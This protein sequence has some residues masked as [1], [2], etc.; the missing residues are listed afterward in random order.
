MA[1]VL[2]QTQTV[3]KTQAPGII[4]NL[5]RVLG[6]RAT[7]V[8]R[9]IFD[10]TAR[11]PKTDSRN[12]ILDQ[13]GQ[14]TDL[15]R[16]MVE[17][18]SRG[19]RGLGTGL[20]EIKEMR[21]KL[22][23]LI[24]QMTE[25]FTKV[26]DP[27]RMNLEGIVKELKGK[28]AYKSTQVVGELKLGSDLVAQRF[29]NE[30][31][32]V[33]EYFVNHALREA[34]NKNVLG[35]NYNEAE[36]AQISKVVD[37]GGGRVSFHIIGLPESV[38]KKWQT[39]QHDAIAKLK[40]S[41]VFRSLDDKNIM[42]LAGRGW[43]DPCEVELRPELKAPLWTIPLKLDDTSIPASELAHMVEQKVLEAFSRGFGKLSQFDPL[44][45][46]FKEAIREGLSRGGF[47]VGPDGRINSNAKAM[48]AEIEKA[49][50]ALKGL[51]AR[52]DKAI[53]ALSR[54]RGVADLTPLEE[55]ADTRAEGSLGKI[56]GAAKK[57]VDRFQAQQKVHGHA[58]LEKVLT[59]GMKPVDIALAQAKVEAL[60]DKIIANIA[61]PAGANVQELVY[62][63]PSLVSNGLNCLA[64]ALLGLPAVA[65][66]S[67]GELKR[68]LREK[69]ENDLSL[70]K[71]KRAG[72]GEKFNLNLVEE[73]EAVEGIFGSVDIVNASNPL[74]ATQKMSASEIADQYS[75]NAMVA[76]ASKIQAEESNQ[77]QSIFM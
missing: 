11:S 49:M 7:R 4:G 61:T 44:N 2:R 73:P 45:I 38:R 46:Q 12:S 19:A 60:A 70:K 13:L 6:P 35:L 21:N 74:L 28:G 10:R 64:A 50:D 37:S 43:V 62:M 26:F 41:E 53:E 52:L 25:T 65:H 18:I 57:L 39:I 72:K 77:E 48:V 63:M 54:G 55:L 68:L 27:K 71:A 24:D 36:F 17:G 33:N 9:P 34:I 15:A 29:P 5:G 32:K 22:S 8:H 67:I 3:A 40:Q 56:M 76:A 14:V 51:L 23:S 75:V 66:V 1:T 31:L 20:S 16:R 30:F 47:D 59:K 42:Y 69:R 58:S